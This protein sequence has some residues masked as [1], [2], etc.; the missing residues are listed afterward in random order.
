MASVAR[1]HPS[2]GG[3]ELVQ[4]TPVRWRIDPHGDMR[5]PGIVFSS[6]ALLPDISADRSLEQVVNVATLPGVVEASY[7]MPTVHSGNSFPSRRVAAPYVAQC[8]AVSPGGAG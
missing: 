2:S 6:E 1:T 4:E 3:I 8:G 5:V 7:A